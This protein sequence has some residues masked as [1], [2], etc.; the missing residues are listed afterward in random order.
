VLLATE[1]VEVE[2]TVEETVD[3]VFEDVGR[4]ELN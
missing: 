1:A 4:E 2:E 3:P